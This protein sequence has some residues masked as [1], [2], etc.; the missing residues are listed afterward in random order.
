MQHHPENDG[1]DGDT[2]E[3]SKSNKTLSYKSKC[4]GMGHCP[5]LV[6]SEFFFVSIL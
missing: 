1:N 4:L 2:S 6:S 3:S 5:H